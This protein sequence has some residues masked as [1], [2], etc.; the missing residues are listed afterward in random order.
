[1]KFKKLSFH[2]S[3][4]Y[5]CVS[6]TLFCTPAHFNKHNAT[7]IKLVFHCFPRY[8]VFGCFSLKETENVLNIWCKITPLVQI[9]LSLI[10]R[11]ITFNKYPLYQTIYF[12]NIDLKLV[13]L[14]RRY[15]DYTHSFSFNRP[16]LC[17]RYI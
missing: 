12:V 13:K 4:N 9:L 1:V 15:F 5:A 2:C 10:T 7:F 14:V 6:M 3:L 8:N 16:K 11:E 17:P